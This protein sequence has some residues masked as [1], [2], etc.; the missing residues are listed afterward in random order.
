[1]NK[2]YANLIEHRSRPSVLTVNDDG[3]LM[4]GEVFV[5]GAARTSPSSVRPEPP[6]DRRKIP[7]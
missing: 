4:R 7:L 5:R 2:Y 1:V 3:V 6:A